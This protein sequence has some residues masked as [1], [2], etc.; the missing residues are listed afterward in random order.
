MIG[1]L[2]NTFDSVLMM[3]FYNKYLYEMIVSA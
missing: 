2:P 3:A 1:R